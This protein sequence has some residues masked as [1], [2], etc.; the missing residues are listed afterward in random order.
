MKMKIKHIFSLV[1][2]LIFILFCYLGCDFAVSIEQRVDIFITDLNT[3][4]DA[5]Y[6]NFLPDDPLD[7]DAIKAASFWQTPFPVGDGTPYSYS[8]GDLD[9]SNPS[10]VTLELYGPS[11][12]APPKTI[13]FVMIQDGLS[14]Y[15]R[16]L[17]KEGV[18]AVIPIP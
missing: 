18:G 13:T 10:S 17:Y 11:A 2:L 1:L 3:D 5:A 7:Y 15:I 14:W 12:F 16:E 6:L 8:A 4:R 9:T